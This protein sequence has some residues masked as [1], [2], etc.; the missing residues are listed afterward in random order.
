MDNP[1]VDILV[2]GEGEITFAELLHAFLNGADLRNV[3]GISFRSKE[4][5][6]GYIHTPSRERIKDLT[7]LPSPFLN[8]VFDEL[9]ERHR[10]QITGTIWET[11][12]GCP[13]SCTFCDWGQATQSK[14]TIHEQTRLFSELDWMSKNKI[15]YIF[16]ADANFG[17]KERD[18]QIAEYLG[19]LYAATGYPRY[20]L[21]NWMKNSQQK[22]ISIAD[23]LHRTGVG[24]MVTLSMQ[25]FDETT[26][27][28]IKRNNIDLHTFASLKREYNARGIATYS[29]LLLGLPGETYDSF[30]NGLIKVLSPLPTDHFALYLTTVLPNAE[31][32]KPEYREKYGMETRFTKAT[33]MRQR[34]V[35]RDIYEVDEVIVATKAMP[36]KDWCRAYRFGYLL[37]ALHNMR[38]AFYI[39]EFLREHYEI[40]PKDFLEYLIESA[41]LPGRAPTLAKLLEHLDRYI[42]SILQNKNSMLPFEEYPDYYW[43]PH[44]MCFL[45][46]YHNTKSFYSDLQNLTLDFVTE[47]LGSKEEL[48]KEVCLYQEAASPLNKSKDTFQ[49]AFQFRLLNYFS[50]VMRDEKNIE[51]SKEKCILEFDP[52]YRRYKV[53]NDLDFLLAAVR[54]CAS[55]SI[56]MCNVTEVKDS[57]AVVKC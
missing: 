27:L 38:L 23:A 50:A 29:E 21:I 31:M 5:E 1:E 36:L 17:I 48:V 22:T 47:R 30:T 2:H 25:S 15:P 41:R 35:N 45:V 46:A 11:N 20:L 6:T 10:A 51:I 43:E 12:R 34:T 39:I 24:F 19:G 40:S 57:L 56:A 54:S 9:L 44:E 7:I 53:L 55:G 8:G 3:L 33:V 26:L 16:A 28:A 37:R 4:S 32:A 14:V 52:L 18:L 42:N 13:F 49:M